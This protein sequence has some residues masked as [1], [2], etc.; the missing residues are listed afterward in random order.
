MMDGVS[1]SKVACLQCSDFNF[2]TKRTH[3]GFFLEYV[4]K[5]SCLTKKRRRKEKVFFMRKKS[6]VDQRLNK[7][8]ALQYK[9]LDFIKKAE[10][11]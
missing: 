7:I 8:G 1:F 6:M 9:A 2:A 11:I 5:T 10:L 4:P 3:H